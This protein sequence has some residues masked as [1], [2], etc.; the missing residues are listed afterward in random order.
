MK[1]RNQQERA[2]VMSALATLEEHA[3]A[4]V[5]LVRAYIGKL[6]RKLLVRKK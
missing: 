2:D 6:E 3:P 1:T 5:K 4:Y